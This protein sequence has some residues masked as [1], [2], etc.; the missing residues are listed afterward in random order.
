[1]YMKPALAVVAFGLS[2]AAQQGT[3]PPMPAPA[4]PTLPADVVAESRN[5]L[6]VVRRDEL[7]AKGR[8]LY[9]GVVGDARRL[10]GLQGP[11]G[12]R[13]H[14]PA[15]GEIVLRLNNYLRFESGLGARTVELAILVVARE[16][17]SQFEW[18]SH[19][20]AALRAG[21]PRELVDLVKRR[22]PTAG[23][24]E[25]DAAVIDL[26]REAL[27]RRT[28]SSSTY[29]RALAVLGPKDLVDV[30]ILIGE[31]SATAVLLNTF[32]QQLP[33]GQPPLLPPR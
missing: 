30:T 9:D 29:A 8:Q 16:L 24:A 17:D 13:L 23:L 26:G 28:V 2:V 11:G 1:M 5:R 32:D 20:P 15:M 3:K 4:G 31:Y 21:V 27:S 12:I 6:P 14:S 7:D 33:P 10:T 22:G 25:R 19:E 18:T